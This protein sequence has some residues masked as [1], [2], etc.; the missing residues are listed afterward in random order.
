VPYRR[1]DGDAGAAMGM[2]ASA[3]AAVTIGIDAGTDWS[4]GGSSGVTAAGIDTCG[5]VLDVPCSLGTAVIG[6][7]SAATVS[8][9]SGLAAWAL[10]RMASGMLSLGSVA[11]GAA[12][13]FLVL[14]LV[15][16]DR[17]RRG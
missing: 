14:V 13:S 4:G 7:A 10:S 15:R 8:W 9:F 3:G 1:H 5:G 12:S 11:C 2:A 17:C 6:V 16:M